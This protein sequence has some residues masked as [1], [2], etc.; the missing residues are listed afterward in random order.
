MKLTKCKYCK[1]SYKPKEW[2]KEDELDTCQGCRITMSCLQSLS[3]ALKLQGKGEKSKMYW[4]DKIDNILKNDQN[5][6]TE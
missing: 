1:H 4:V 5:K 3:V 2:H 6:Q